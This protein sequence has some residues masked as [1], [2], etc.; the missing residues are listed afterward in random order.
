MARVAVTYEQVASVANAL[1]ASGIRDPGTKAIRE[2]LARRAG[3]GAPTG[4]PNTI[5]RHLDQWRLKDRPL[6]QTEAPQLPPQLASDILRALNAAATVAR[7]KA[8]ERL[9]MLQTELAE[10]AAAGE[11]NEV[12]IDDL[13][14]GL[15]AMTT[16]RDQA[17]ALATERNHELARLATEVERARAAAHAAQVDAAK[18]QLQLEG[19]AAAQ[20]ELQRLRELLQTAED[21]RRAAEQ[22]AAVT[23]AQL[24]ASERRADESAERERVANERAERLAHDLTEARVQA[25]SHLSA[26]DRATAELAAQRAELARTREAVSAAQSQA[27]E[28]RGQLAALAPKQP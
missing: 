1:Y 5:Q 26:L 14:Q 12:R 22:S 16:Q 11:A 9:A 15:A 2:E 23:Q 17:V 6:D 4:S 8:E 19:L 24:L 27:A 25:Q 7:E 3:P 10:V 28:L 20:T 18:L 13:T 21:A